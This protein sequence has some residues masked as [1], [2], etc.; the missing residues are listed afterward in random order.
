MPREINAGNTVDYTTPRII[1]SIA[2]LDVEDG[3]TRW[4]MYLL[5]YHLGGGNWIIS[6]L[7]GHVQPEDL[8]LQTLFLVGHDC[9]LPADCLPCMVFDTLTAGFL[10]HV[11][12]QA[13]QIANA[14]RAAAPPTSVWG[15]AAAGAAAAHW[16]F[17]DPGYFFFGDCVNNMLVGDHTRFVTVGSVGIVTLVPATLFTDAVG[18]PCERI[19]DVDLEVWRMHKRLGLGQDSQ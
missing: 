5:C 19:R 4:E 14:I 6:D 8:S 3:T 1:E 17:S 9:A 16:R 13:A 18:T 10:A 12:A 7:H 11:R 15:G 2:L